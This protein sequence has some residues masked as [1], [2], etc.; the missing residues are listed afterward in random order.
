M[1][2]SSIV[3]SLKREKIFS[4][5][6]KGTRVD[7]R[8]LEEARK[9]SIE[10]GVI[11]KANGSARIK[12]GDTE[13]VTG[14]K[15]QPDKPFPDLGN[16][17]IFICTAEVLPLAHP[18][19]EPGPPGEE[20]I[21]LARVV[22]RGIRESGMVDLTKLVLEE[23]KSVIGVFADNSVIDYDGNL[24][25]ACSYA[26]TSAVLSCKIPKWE[27]IDDVPTLVENQES[28][29]PITT[30]PVSV[31]MARLGDY[32]IVDPNSDEWSCMDARITITTNS[33]GQ[34]VALQKGGKNGF[35]IDQLIKCSE[36]SISQGAK[37]RKIIEESAGGLT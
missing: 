31:T 16:K 13:V 26:S 37:I 27:L 21:E 7:G 19:V 25:D 9:L 22:D 20:V 14:V 34:I 28:N 32:I 11:P 30:I 18:S 4:L 15:V 29:P 3:D 10:T 8:G 5:L 23:N 12:L 24:F 36:I 33:N 6:E 35:T 17:G 1:S 2:N